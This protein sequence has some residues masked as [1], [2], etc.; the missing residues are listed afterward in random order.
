MTGISASLGISQLKRI[1]SKVA[2]CECIL[3]KKGRLMSPSLICFSLPREAVA[4]M[5]N[6]IDR[7]HFEFSNINL[8]L[9]SLGAKYFPTLE[10]LQLALTKVN[11]ETII[12]SKQLEFELNQLFPS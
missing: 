8:D 5:Q 12:W 4:G 9:E 1:K 10:Q 6:Y 3:T 7:P 2:K 11:E